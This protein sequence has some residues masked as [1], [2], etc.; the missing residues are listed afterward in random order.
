MNP[1]LVCEY[2]IGAY[3]KHSYASDCVTIILILCMPRPCRRC[4]C[5]TMLTE[6]SDHAPPMGR[7]RDLGTP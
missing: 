3:C 5:C 6:S 1:S 4:V 2:W 7:G